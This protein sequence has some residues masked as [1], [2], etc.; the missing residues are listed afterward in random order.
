MDLFSSNDKFLQFWPNSK[1]SY[2]DRID[3][4]ARFVI[5]ASFIAYMMKRDNRIIGLAA[6]VLIVIF[7]F[8]SRNPETS[9]SIPR[10]PESFFPESRWTDRQFYTT[11]D[12]NDLDGFLNFV[13]G[14]KRDTC[15]TNPDMCDADTHPRMLESYNTRG[16]RLL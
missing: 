7:L 3:S 13:H 11:P 4:A 9:Q 12:N 8:R 6:F 16:G 15:R 10:D 2:K 1:Q 14:G 5:Y